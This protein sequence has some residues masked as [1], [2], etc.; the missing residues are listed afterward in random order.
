MPKRKINKLTE[1]EFH[2]CEEYLK[3]GNATRAY[4]KIY[5][6]N[7]KDAK[8]ARHEAY[9]IKH[10]P[11]IQKYLED[12]RDDIRERT[13]IE[14]AELLLPLQEIA[15]AN[16]TDYIDLETLEGLTELK[17]LPNP[18]AI[19]KIKIT[20]KVNESGNDQVFT[21]LEL[22]DKIKANESIRKHLG[23]DKEPEDLSLNNLNIKITHVSSRD[24]DEQSE[25]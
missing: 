10:R 13:N 22:Y 24:P 4:N 21:E 23:L 9:R 6:P 5:Q 25:D 1:Q 3:D 8:N 16:M 12:A 20:R 19:K 17:D 11:H 2:W 18:H 7:L 14:V 15:Q